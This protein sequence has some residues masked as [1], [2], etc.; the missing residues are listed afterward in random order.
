MESSRELDAKLL[1]GRYRVVRLLAEGGMGQVYLA[2]IEGAEGFTRPVVVKVMRLEMRATE[3]GNRLFRREAQI[4]S[5]MQHPA[6]SN[7]IDFGIE[8]GAHIMVLEYLHGYPISRWV[9]FRFAKNLTIPVDVCL[10]IVRRIL[11]A[12]HY[13][14]HFDAEEGNVVEIVHRDVAA[15]NVI[16]DRKGFVYLLDFGIAS[17]SGPERPATSSS[18]VFRGKLGY[19]APETL[20]GAPATPQADQYSAAVL[21]VELLTL[22]TPF[23]SESMGETVHRMMSEAPPKV[24]ERRSDCPE[25]LDEALARALSKKPAERFESVRGLSRVLRHFQQE[26]DE[27][28]AADLKNMI[29]ADFEELPNVVAVEPLRVREEALARIFPSLDSAALDGAV[30]AGT[31][32]G[33]IST[34]PAPPEKGTNRLLW[35]LVLV[36]GLIALALGAVVALLSNRGDEQVVV[37]GGEQ[38]AAPAV[39]APAQEPENTPSPPLEQQLTSEQQLSRAIQQ[40]GTAF[41]SCFVSHLELAEKNPEATLHF[42]IHAKSPLTDVEVEPAAVAESAL[43]TCLKRAAS[44][45]RFPELDERLSF[46]IPVRARFARLK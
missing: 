37:V 33:L 8:D 32:S 7:I 40:N 3:E 13:A 10:F 35:A 41:E 11:D 36:A 15:D 2:R 39:D 1:L 22:E 20:E 30:G 19:S 26:D 17:I 24:A 31:R 45:V 34:T 44:G 43:G 42:T 23:F 12:L 18:G 16:L 9:D 21:L 14:H 29:Q 28:V 46:R 4:L 25:G 5:K 27:E 38:N 6:I